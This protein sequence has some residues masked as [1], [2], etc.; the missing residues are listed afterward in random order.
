MK[1]TLKGIAFSSEEE[2][3]ITILAD[4]TKKE[5]VYHVGDMVK[6]AQIIKISQNRIT[7]L[8]V[9]GQH[10]TIFL[11]ESD[12]AENI[13]KEEL[14]EDVVKKIDEKNYEIDRIKFPQKVP[15]LGN[16]SEILS[17]MTAYDNGKPIG[18]RV[19]KIDPRS[20]G[21]QIGLKENDIILSINSIKTGDKKERMKILDNVYSIKK[22][23]KLSVVLLRD[24][25]EE[26]LLFK[27]TEIKTKKKRFFEPKKAEKE[28]EKDKLFKLSNL[29][30]REEQRR[31]FAKKHNQPQ[32]QQQ[33][34]IIDE[35]RK[36]LLENIRERVRNT[37]IR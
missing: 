13:T 16:L 25:K 1:I 28:T 21:N 9:N 33:K 34:N 17:L 19:S 18:I 11:R 22:D 4:E 26:E 36:R 24:S 31:V 30:K 7:L 14:W 6:D 29:Q 5:G 35:I 27:I 23:K 37:R 32:A 3:S 10:E 20:I 15:S 12:N 2:K 8:R